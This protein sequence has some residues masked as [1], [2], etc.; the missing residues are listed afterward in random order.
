LSIPSSPRSVQAS[1]PKSYRASSLFS[2]GPSSTDYESEVSAQVPVEEEKQDD[3]DDL[4]FEGS[5]DP[6]LL[7]EEKIL[8][9]VT[10]VSEPNSSPSI[11]TTKIV[12]SPLSQDPLCMFDS[13]QSPPS[14]LHTGGNVGSSARTS[15]EPANLLIAPHVYHQEVLIPENDTLSQLQDIGVYSSPFS[16]PQSRA[17]LPLPSQQSPS[18]ITHRSPPR[19]SPPLAI[20]ADAEHAGDLHIAQALQDTETSRSRYTLRKRGLQQEKPYFYDQLQYRHLMQHNPDAIVPPRSP[21][22]GGDRRRKDDQYE[23]ESQD[24]ECS[25]SESRRK[26][27]SN[28]CAPNLSDDLPYDKTFNGLL[29]DISDDD[30]E[31]TT[32][33]RKEARALK[34]KERKERREREERERQQKAKKSK[35]FPLERE[36]ASNAN[37]GSPPRQVCQALNT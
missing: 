2:T 19:R 4:D 10:G 28:V 9:P 6:L 26:T 21:T 34:K 5:Q 1:S 12:C 16:S 31:G 13:T 35:A 32:E 15:P 18:P 30:L 25:G 29:P 24:K 23:E 33:L 20:T 22:R 8:S 11:S 17:N 37:E 14:A 3:I 7:S 36:H 27:P